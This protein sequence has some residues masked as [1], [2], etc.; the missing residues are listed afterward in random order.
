MNDLIAKLL[1]LISAME[2]NAYFLLIAIGVIWVVDFVNWW[3]L[4]SRLN[5]LGIYPRHIFGLIGIPISPILHGHFNHL[6]FNTFP[7]FILANLVLLKGF[8]VFYCVTAA[9][10]F[11]S[12]II[13]WIIGR[14]AFHIGASGLIMGYWSYLLIQAFQE[15]TAMSYILGAISLYYFGG[16]LM[17]LF[18]DKKEVSWEAH[19]AGFVSGIGA[20]FLTPQ[21]LQLYGTY[22]T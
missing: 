20:Y 4:G 10:V 15:Q 5:I 6:F 21:L 18:P 17:D 19:L 1:V 13:V 7:L 3:I 22:I 16:L 12:G 2:A 11:G 9:I 14:S 8:P